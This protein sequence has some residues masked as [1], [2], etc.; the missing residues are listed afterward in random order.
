M[1]SVDAGTIIKNYEEIVENG[2]H[3]HP[4]IFQRKLIQGIL[5]AFAEDLV[6]SVLWERDGDNVC[7]MR[8]W[9]HVIKFVIAMAPRRL[10]L[11]FSLCVCTSSYSLFYNVL[12]FHFFINILIGKTQATA[13]SIVARMIIIMKYSNRDDHQAVFSTSKFDPLKKRLIK[14]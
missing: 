11:S 9:T 12:L 4:H 7:A 5:N 1:K 8:K 2:F 6:G 14:S 10:G 13:M 3:H